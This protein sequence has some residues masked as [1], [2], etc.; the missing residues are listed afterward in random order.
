VHDNVLENVNEIWTGS[1]EGNGRIIQIEPNKADSTACSGTPNTDQ[2]RLSDITITHNSI[3]GA[4]GAGNGLT[5]AWVFPSTPTASDLGYNVTV[6]DNILPAGS[7]LQN[8]DLG[9]SPHPLTPVFNA[10]FS[11]Y[12]FD[13]N[14]ITGVSA[15]GYSCTDFP[16]PIQ[17]FCTGIG[18]PV[19]MTNIGFTNW[20]SGSG[21]NYQLCSASGTPAGCTAPS[22]YHNAADDGTDVGANMSL[23]N[24]YTNN[25]IQGTP[26]HP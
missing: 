12:T 26:T 6:T 10:Y 20:N 23:V 7:Y 9:V 21:G 11:S 5:A 17:N 13:H 15:A 8:T 1:V 18:Q 25:V 2:C 24:T 16:S 14:A 22:P 3:V 4:D 19:A